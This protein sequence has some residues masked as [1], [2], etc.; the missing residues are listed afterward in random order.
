M[1]REVAHIATMRAAVILAALLAATRAILAALLAACTLAIAAA[2]HYVA[3][4]DN[5]DGN[6]CAFKSNPDWVGQH[7]VKGLGALDLTVDSGL[8]S[9]RGGGLAGG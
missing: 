1:D 6:N 9:D 5:P 2:A 7:N 8:D 3:D 4:G